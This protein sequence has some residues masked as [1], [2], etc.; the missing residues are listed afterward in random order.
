M[1]ITFRY[2]FNSPEF[3]EFEG[4]CRQPENIPPHL[5][6]QVIS[7]LH[8]YLLVTSGSPIP[9]ISTPST[10]LTKMTALL[11]EVKALNNQ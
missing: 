5:K 11:N 9:I 10:L 3:R 1:C 8:L 6:D 2:G 7:L 4:L